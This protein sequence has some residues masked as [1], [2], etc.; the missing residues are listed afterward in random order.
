MATW[1]R[2]LERTILQDERIS[3]RTQVKPAIL[4][5]TEPAISDFVPSKGIN[6][7]N[8]HQVEEM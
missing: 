7:V 5:E 2:I 4:T 8:A 6:Y 3:A 1:T